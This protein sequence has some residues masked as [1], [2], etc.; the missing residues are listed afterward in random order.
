MP[1][2]ERTRR[3]A[4][5]AVHAG[6]D[7]EGDQLLDLFR[8]HA[9]GFGHQRDGGLVQ[10]GEDIDRHLPQRDRAV[11]DQQQRH[12]EDDQALLERG[13]DDEIEHGSADLGQ[14]AGA[15]D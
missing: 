4:G 8:R 1:E 7:R 15:L 10:V 3:H 6:F 13:V 9:A 2:T 12:A 11:D 14:Q 5:H